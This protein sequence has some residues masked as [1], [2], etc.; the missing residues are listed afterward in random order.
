MLK[1]VT[2]ASVNQFSETGRPLGVG[3]P[4]SDITTLLMARIKWM[5]SPKEVRVTP[6][7]AWAKPARMKMI[8]KRAPR[9]AGL[10]RTQ[11]EIASVNIEMTTIQAIW[12]IR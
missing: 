12:P 6:L 7:T 11:A 5:R 8:A 10:K 2:A 1:A 4:K 3:A 9:A